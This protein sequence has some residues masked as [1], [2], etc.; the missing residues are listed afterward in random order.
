MTGF[1]RPRI[2]RQTICV[3]LTLDNMAHDRVK[4]FIRKSSDVA[5]TTLV[6]AGER[7]FLCSARSMLRPG[8]GAIGRYC[9]AHPHARARP[10][11]HRR[12]PCW[13]YIRGKRGW[14][15]EIRV[16]RGS[17]RNEG[18]VVPIRRARMS[19]PVSVRRSVHLSLEVEKWLRAR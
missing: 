9:R 8:G 10:L 12:V 16:C 6:A 17:R 15:R 1:H 3:G 7:N 4:K 19:R 13:C 11:W 2:G 18:N 14:I 5:T